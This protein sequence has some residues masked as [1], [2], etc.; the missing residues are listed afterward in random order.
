MH[1]PPRTGYGRT[2]E[3]AESQFKEVTSKRLTESV[4]EI[5]VHS[6]G[7]QC[8]AN[9]G[10]IKIELNKGSAV[11]SHKP[12][13]EALF[14]PQDGPYTRRR[15]YILLIHFTA[16]VVSIDEEGLGPRIHAWHRDIR[17][18]ELSSGSRFNKAG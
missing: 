6:G 15:P 7:R 3:K 4:A 14:S 1:R 5:P 2:N 8:P 10:C 9:G 16:I 18:T 11:V 13:L 12:R 17:I